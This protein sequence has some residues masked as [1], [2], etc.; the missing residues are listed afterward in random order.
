V[1]PTVVE[2]P[3]LAALAREYAAKQDPLPEGRSGVVT[4]ACRAA[5]IHRILTGKPLREG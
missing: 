1:S 3:K 5:T 4:A 2:D